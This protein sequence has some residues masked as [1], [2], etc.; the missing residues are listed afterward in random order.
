[1]TRDLTWRY[2]H[3][4]SQLDAHNAQAPVSHRAK[5]AARISFEYVVRKLI[6][7]M[8]G[9][10]DD[11]RFNAAW[12][13]FC[14]E[15]LL[16][17][18]RVARAAEEDAYEQ[19]RADALRSYAQGTDSVPPGLPSFGARYHPS[20]R[21]TRVVHTLM[22]NGRD[23]ANSATDVELA[24]EA[25]LTR[26]P[27]ERSADP[28]HHKTT[29]DF[30]NEYLDGQSTRNGDNR[31]KTELGPIIEFMFALID[32]KRPR[33][34]TREDFKLLNSAIPL[35]PISKGIPKEHCASLHARYLYRLNN[36]ALPLDLVTGTTITRN[37][38]SGLNRFFGWMQK[39]RLIEQGPVLDLVTPQNR[40]SLPRDSFDD[41]EVLA[42]VALPLFTGCWSQERCWSAG[43]ILVQGSLY[44]TY[45]ILLL[46]GMRPGEVGSLRLSDIGDVDGIAYF[47]LRA[48]DARKGRV[49]LSEMRSQKTKNASRIVPIH[50]LLIELGLLEHRDHMQRA[51]VDRLLPDCEPYRR[52][53]GRL[54][55]SQDITKSWRYLKTKYAVF[56]RKDITLYSSR[57]LVAQ[58]IDELK[59]SERTRG[60]VLGH[61]T[62]PGA[63][64]N[65]GRNG[66]LS[67]D[68]LQILTGITNP[69][70]DQMR[71]LLLQAK[72]RAD[73]GELTLLRPMRPAARATR[74]PR[75]S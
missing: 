11:G 75:S 68:E 42:L 1:M 31:A 24:R 61:S 73:T 59:I 66:L 63:A 60:R 64:G 53:D 62:V 17:E 20:R 18:E 14:Q 52:R 43:K 35:I 51:G 26:Q 36:P 33:D 57:H 32:D 8:G 46:T 9:L 19:G 29:R 2:G 38:H 27:V 3:V 70:I 54:R 4:L 72:R 67:M 23:V 48:F 40:S 7:D 16:A 49:M 28:D 45:L 34:Y 65:Y 56:S 21:Q 13:S 15:N 71:D 50:P 41:A 47:D 39:N 58:W 6:D 55:W 10:A 74:R 25:I 22:G 69:L 44:W 30:Y 12:M 37:Y 5:L